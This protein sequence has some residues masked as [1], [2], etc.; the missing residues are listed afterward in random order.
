MRCC[1]SYIRCTFPTPLFFYTLPRPSQPTQRPTTF[2]S[3]VEAP[4]RPP[5]CAP[6]KANEVRSNGCRCRGPTGSPTGLQKWVVSFPRVCAGYKR[7]QARGRMR[8]TWALWVC[9]TTSQPGT[10]LGAFF[11]SRLVWVDVVPC[12]MTALLHS[13]VAFWTSELINVASNEQHPRRCTTKCLGC[14]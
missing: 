1:L 14:R 5:G 7:W 2:K 8:A 12:G 4:R 13:V 9:V 6:T 3:Y 11:S 10:M